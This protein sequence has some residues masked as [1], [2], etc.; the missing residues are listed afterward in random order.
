MVAAKEKWMNKYQYVERGS[1]FT[2]VTYNRAK[3]NAMYPKKGAR[4]SRRK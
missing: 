1:I 4:Y 2:D 3:K